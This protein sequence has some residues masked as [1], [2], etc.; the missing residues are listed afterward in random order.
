M[1]RDMRRIY[2]YIYKYVCGVYDDLCYM[3]IFS[4]FYFTLYRNEDNSLPFFSLQYLFD[5]EMRR[6]G[7]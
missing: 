3:V 6:Y 2:I 4:V 5:G 7:G 1:L